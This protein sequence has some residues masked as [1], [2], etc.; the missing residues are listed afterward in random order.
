MLDRILRRIKQV[1]SLI[2]WRVAISLAKKT[3]HKGILICD[4]T[5]SQS[6]HAPTFVKDVTAALDQ[7]ALSFPDA[8]R[9]SHNAIRGI[10]RAEINNNFEYF[11]G[12]KLLLLRI[13]YQKIGLTQTSEIVDRLTQL[14][15]QV[16]RQI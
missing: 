3:F 9:I 8:F 2:G 12:P 10:A 11:S 14:A 16:S 15:N 4:I 13:D 6:T 5:S 1:P 7:L